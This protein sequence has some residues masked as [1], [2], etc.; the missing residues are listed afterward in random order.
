MQDFLIERGDYPEELYQ[1]FFATYGNKINGSIGYYQL[2]YSIN[3][4]AKAQEELNKINSEQTTFEQ[5]TKELTANDADGL[6]FDYVIYN[7]FIQNPE[8][9]NNTL[10]QLEVGQ[11]SGL[12]KTSNYIYIVK[13]VDKPKCRSLITSFDQLDEP[14]QTYVHSYANTLAKVTYSQNPISYELMNMQVKTYEMPLK[15]SYSKS[16]FS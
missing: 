6:N 15:T 4:E 13:V 12:I 3:D 8:E 10:E 9:V 7:G 2:E 14:T 11:V 1:D 16:I 5:A